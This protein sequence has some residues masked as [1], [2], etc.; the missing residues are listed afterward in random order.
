MER[1]DGGV[2]PGPRVH[3][4]TQTH[5]PRLEVRCYL[6]Q[7]CAALLYLHTIQEVALGALLVTCG[8]KKECVERAFLGQCTTEWIRVGPPRLAAFG[9]V[10]LSLASAAF[11]CGLPLDKLVQVLVAFGRTVLLGGGV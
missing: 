9:A 10:A 6:R 3:G 4:T 8:T 1:W 7:V 11:A 2:P 5:T